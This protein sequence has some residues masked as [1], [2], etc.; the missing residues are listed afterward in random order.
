MKKPLAL[1]VVEQFSG[2]HET[3]LNEDA[4]DVIGEIVNVIAG[5]AKQHIDK[6][7]ALVITLP[8]IVRGESFSLSWTG[9]HP[10]IVC[11]PFSIFD[12]EKFVLSITIDSD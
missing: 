10:R 1:R 7:F 4:L 3:E 5:H 2:V 6:D 8:T 9:S 12:D 11:I